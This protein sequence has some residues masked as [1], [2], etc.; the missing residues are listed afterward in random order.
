MSELKREPT[1]RYLFCQQGPK[2]P[3][4]D[5]EFL[6]GKKETGVGVGWGREWV[7]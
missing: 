5:T 6:G 3:F 4:R 2:P 7:C 1:D